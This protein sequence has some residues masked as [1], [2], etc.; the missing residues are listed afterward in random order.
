MLYE[1]LKRNHT[2]RYRI[3]LLV[4]HPNWISTS[5]LPCCT[6]SVAMTLPEILPAILL[7]SSVNTLV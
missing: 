6:H 5:S 3:Y 2:V 1:L 4:T 7:S